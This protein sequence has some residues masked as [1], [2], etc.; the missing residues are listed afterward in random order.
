MKAD[1]D[2]AAVQVANFQFGNK[3]RV[4]WVD[5]VGRCCKSH[6]VQPAIFVGGGTGAPNMLMQEAGL[7]NVFAN[8]SGNWVCVSQAEVVAAAPDVMVLAHAAWDT[9]VSKLTYLYNHTAFCGMD[10]IKG[11][12]FVQIPFSATTLSPRNGPAALDLAIASMHVRTGTTTPVRT[13]GVSS[14]A[15]A[16]FKA[17]TEF[18]GHKCT[19]DATKV[20]YETTALVGQ[21]QTSHAKSTYAFLPCVLA[22]LM[23]WI[24]AA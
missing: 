4:V 23:A 17:A 2:A 11:A 12:R 3:L 10:A 21:T 1:F 9:A 16:T 19:L 20:L 13:S 5:C 22:S 24:S 18:S 8:K 15:P 7:E 6:P 14:F